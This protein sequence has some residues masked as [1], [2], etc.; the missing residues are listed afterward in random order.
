MTVTEQA[1]KQYQKDLHRL[2]ALRPIEDDFMRCLFKDNI[3][4]E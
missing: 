2:Q 1:D 4:Q 3:L